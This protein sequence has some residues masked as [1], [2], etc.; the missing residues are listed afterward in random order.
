MN[1]KSNKKNNYIR[2][3]RILDII[4]STIM[5]VI[6]S[7]IYILIAFILLIFQG[8]PII[9]KQTRLG[10]NGKEFNIYKFRTMKLSAEELKKTFSKEEKIEY[11]KNFKL[12][13]DPRITKIGKLL[14]KT[15]MDELPQFFNI[16]K[17]DMSFIGPRPIVKAE[18]KKYN[19]KDRKKFLSILPGLIGY[20]QA[21][22]T[23][24]TTYEERKS[25]ELFYVENKSFIF[26]IKIFFK[27]IITVI[28][29][30]IN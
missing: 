24:N 4:I 6:L 17:G 8:R 10:L 21:Y 28:K 25:M 13:K 20:W 16:L 23:S 3:T 7:P 1:Y 9:F 5:I 12:K 11:E 18:L 29:K 2:F 14:R 27:T 19:T 15:S 30:I 22:S 26:D